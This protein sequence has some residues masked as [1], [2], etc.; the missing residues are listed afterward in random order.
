MNPWQRSVW[1][2]ALFFVASLSWAQTE[3]PPAAPVP[4]SNPATFPAVVARRQRH[5]HPEK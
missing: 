5:R 1:T 3:P 4:G 2:L